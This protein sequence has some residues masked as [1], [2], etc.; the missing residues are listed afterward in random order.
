MA[1]EVTITRLSKGYLVTFIDGINY[2]RE[3]VLKEGDAFRRAKE[4]LEDD[5][6]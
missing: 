1:H 2:N 6:E 5:K 3:A 4:I